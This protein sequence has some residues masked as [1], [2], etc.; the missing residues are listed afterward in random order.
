MIE[1]MTHLR[2]LH[3]LADELQA[4]LT[5]YNERCNGRPTRPCW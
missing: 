1:D 5:T 3:A 2:V 4:A